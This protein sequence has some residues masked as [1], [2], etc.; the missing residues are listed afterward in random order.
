MGREIEIKIPLT[1]CQYQ[2]LLEFVG[3]KKIIDG[4]NLLGNLVKIHKK[5]EYYSRYNSRE[6][7]KSAGEPQVLRIRSELIEEKEKSYLTIKR[8]KIEN[9]IE[10]NAEDETFLENAQV[11]RE[12]FELS[13]YHCWFKK[14]KESY[15]IHSTS[16]VFPGL[17][18][19]L[20]VIKVNNLP[21]AE[22]EVT[23]STVDADKVKKA[24]ADFM[25][26]LGLDPDKR[27]TRSWVEIVEGLN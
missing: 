11:L 1:S 18:F 21:Y 9:G 5:D 17:D 4:I 25:S 8:K 19:H 13:G 3:G 7:R 16:K 26:L 15:S 24:I 22:V 14:E 12:L 2:D 20:E 27:D 6:E 10:L 23:D